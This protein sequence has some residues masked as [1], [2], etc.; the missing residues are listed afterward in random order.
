MN[1]TV[2]SGILIVFFLGSGIFIYQLFHAR[3][4]AP[5]LEHNTFQLPVSPPIRSNE[6]QLEN[7]T[8]HIPSS[9]PVTQ[10]HPNT[11]GIA[12]EPATTIVT[13]TIT[14]IDDAT[15][16]LTQPTNIPTPD[17]KQYFR[18]GQP[19]GQNSHHP[20]KIIFSLPGHGST[21]EKDYTAWQPQ[22]IENG[23]YAL[24]SLNWWDGEGEK[25]T[26]YYSP[27]AVVTQITGFLATHG[28]TTDDFVVL[29][30]FSRGSAN[31]YPVKA[32]DVVSGSPVIDAVIS[33]SGKYQSDF[34]LTPSQTSYQS[35]QLYKNVPWVLA[36][37]V[38]DDNPERDGCQGMSETK[39]YLTKSGATVLGLLEDPNGGHGSFHKSS[40]KLAVQ[41]LKLLDALPAA[42]KK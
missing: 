16:T 11:S 15:S 42:T 9:P 29:S 4:S 26:D 3:S 28:Y 6:R 33:A 24:A 5:P 36:C 14:L 38:K 7:G 10:T 12:V 30:G 34:P 37:G 27:D 23:T 2:I 21:A 31:T 19:K 18:F 32:Y 13:E 41:A 40:L 39:E 35:G 1:K 25:I 8:M 17:G 22:L 20:R